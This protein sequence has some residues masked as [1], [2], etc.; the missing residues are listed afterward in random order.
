MKKYAAYVLSAVVV[1]AF[2]VYW[3][4]SRPDQANMAANAGAPAGNAGTTGASGTPG[5]TPAPAPTTTPT[6]A[7]AGNGY[8]DGTYTGP[9]AD[10]IYGQLQVAVTVSGGK[11]TD[12]SW[13]V[14]PDSGGHTLQVSQSALPA[15]K[16]EAIAAQSAKVDIVSGATQTS[17]AFQQSLAAALAQAQ[18]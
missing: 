6:P 5:G 7:A 14:Y 11:I 13:P 8:K 16:Q 1:A 10:A 9:V 4:V 15:L 18:A 3:L 2:I 17:Q 12:V